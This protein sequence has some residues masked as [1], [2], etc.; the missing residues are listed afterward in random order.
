[1]I[2]R[3]AASAILASSL[4]TA[5]AAGHPGRGIQ[6]DSRGR[7]WFIDTT[8]DILWRLDGGELTLVRRGVHSDRLL[9]VGDSAVTAEEYHAGVLGPR[10]QRLAADTSRVGREDAVH[11]A[12]DPLSFVAL[13]SAENAYFV[14]MGRALMLTPGDSIVQRA[15]GLGGAPA[16]AAA[17]RPD[18]WLYVV[19]DNRVWEIPTIGTGKPGVTD[20]TTFRLVSGVAAG[21]S[22]RVCIA[23]YLGQRV[24]LYTGETGVTRG[25]PWYPVGVAIGPDGACYALERRFQYGGAGR[26]FDWASDLFGTPRVRRITATGP[27]EVVA[28][29]RRAGGALPLVTLVLA[30]AAVVVLAFRVRRR[31]RPAS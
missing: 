9:L 23:D 5:P 12:A 30:A 28:V 20:S 31:P 11:L 17:T 13:D 4:F 10:L 18:G 22:A 1:M 24:F 14:L 25:T 16:L 21:D 19:V 6:V 8:R 2:P 3:I 29:V 27:A 7:V 15:H 26:V